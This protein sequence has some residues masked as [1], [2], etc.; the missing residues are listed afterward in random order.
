ME[1]VDFV[2]AWNWTRHPCWLWVAACVE[3]HAHFTRVLL[4]H[5]LSKGPHNPQGGKPED[6]AR[7]INQGFY[8]NWTRVELSAD[9]TFIPIEAV[10]ELFKDIMYKAPLPG[11]RVVVVEG[12]LNVNATNALLKTLEEPP[13]ETLWILWASHWGQ[14]LPTLRSRCQRVRVPHLTSNENLQ[15]IAWGS[16]GMDAQINKWGKL[17]ALMQL[18][19][20][21]ASDPTALKTLWDNTEQAWFVVDVYQRLVYQEVMTQPNSQGVERW[22]ALASWFGQAKAAHLDPAHTLIEGV[23]LWQGQN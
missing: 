14:V 17:S 10:R 16:A 8:P 22:H 11:W 9:A 20:T 21:P 2:Q 13:P 7:G 18:L 5:V 1:T 15:P 6:V 19:Q 4:Q 3:D 23:R 12:P